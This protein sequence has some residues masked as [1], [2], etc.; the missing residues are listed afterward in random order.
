MIVNPDKLFDL[1]KIYNF[2]QSSL[3]FEAYLQAIGFRDSVA[4]YLNKVYEYERDSFA[5]YNLE[6]LNRWRYNPQFGFTYTIDEVTETSLIV[7]VVIANYD[8]F[9]EGTI[10]L[11]KPLRIAYADIDEYVDS[12]VKF[13]KMT[14]DC[15]DNIENST[16]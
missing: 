1:K 12:A 13:Y 16:K 2:Y 11:L 5:K 6:R 9:G 7:N 10:D 3:N 8:D 14:Q 4:Y 15:I